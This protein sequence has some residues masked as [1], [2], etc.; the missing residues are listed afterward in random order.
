MVAGQIESSLLDRERIGNVK[1]VLSRTARH[2]CPGTPK[3]L[4][5]W[6][7]ASDDGVEFIM[8]SRR[9]AVSIDDRA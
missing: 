8:H 5:E 6:R 2:G 1:K 3:I 9:D 4:P 7:K